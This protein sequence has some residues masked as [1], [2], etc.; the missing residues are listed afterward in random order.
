MVIKGG[1][2]PHQLARVFCFQI[3]EK[4]LLICGH[5]HSTVALGF[6]PQ[7][8][9]TCDVEKAIQGNHTESVNSRAAI[10]PINVPS[11]WPLS[12]WH[13][14]TEIENFRTNRI[15]KAIEHIL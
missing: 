12:I 9:T 14:I 8:R 10:V 11:M 13:E 2:L 15:G 5:F 7:W 4:R 3:V 1:Q 6:L